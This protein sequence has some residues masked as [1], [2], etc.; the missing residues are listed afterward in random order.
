MAPRLTGRKS[1]GAK[2]SNASSTARTVAVKFASGKS[3][4]IGRNTRDSM[5]QDEYVAE[6]N[7]SVAF[8]TTPYP[9]NPGQSAVFPRFSKEAVLYEKWVCVL[10]EFYYKPEV[11]Q[12]APNGTTG[13]VMLSFDYDPSDS[14]PA[15]KQQ[16][17][18]TD[19]HSDGMP[20]ESIRLKLDANELNVTQRGKFVRPAGLPGSSDIKTYDGGILYVSTV[21]NQSA[22]VVG[23]LRVR[24]H[25]RLHKPVLESST[26]APVNYHMTQMNTLVPQLVTTGVVTTILLPNVVTNGIGVVNN[27]GVITLPPGNYAVAA[28]VLG[29]GASLTYVAL[30]FFVNGVAITFAPNQNFGAAAGALAMGVSAHYYVS[31]TG[32]TTI[33]L[34]CQLNGTGLAAQGNLQL[35]SM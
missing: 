10:A 3:T 16:V 30:Q 1:A 29:T 27:S 35:I 18:D 6:V 22:A 13:K 8:A 33:A 24:Y 14:P 28:D 12:F 15:T 9:F 5:I 34:L 25:F 11:S 23:E 26:T 17:Q 4:F 7:G 2:T 20:W 32:S 31:S 19:P 21:A